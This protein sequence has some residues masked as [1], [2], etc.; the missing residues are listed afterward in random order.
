[1]KILHT[2]ASCGW[3]GQE[4]RILTESKGMMQ[5]GHEVMIVAPSIAPI[6]VQAKKMGIP[7]A[8][9]AMEKKRF[10]Q[11]FAVRKWL[12]NNPVDVVNTHSSTDSWLVAIARLGINIPLV[13]TRHI[14]PRYQKIKP[15]VGCIPKVVIM[16]QPQVSCC[17]KI[18]F[19]V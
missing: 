19:S 5:R 2:E 8:A 3:G 4:I 15:L 16:S 9:L 10:K 14:S 11:L 12:K 1:M 17:A 7:H 6:L 13:R 18:L